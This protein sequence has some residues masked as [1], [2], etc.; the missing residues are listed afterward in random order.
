[1]IL[2]EWPRGFAFNKT[3]HQLLRYYRYRQDINIPQQQRASQRSL[4]EVFFVISIFKWTGSRDRI[5]INGK[6]RTVH[7]YLTWF[8]MSSLRFSWKHIRELTFI[9]VK[10]NEFLRSLRHFLLV[11]WLN[12]WFLLVRCSSPNVYFQIA[13][14]PFEDHGQTV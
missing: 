6:R 7:K 8:L 5:Q 12:S 2:R 1:M 10:S 11:H 3:F 4:G 14:R 9:R 13:K